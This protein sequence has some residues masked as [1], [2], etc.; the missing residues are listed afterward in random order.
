M[1]CIRSS[2]SGWELFEVVDAG[3]GKIALKGSNN[4]YVSSENGTASMICNK[5]VIG[6]TEK[7]TFIRI[8]DSKVAFRGNN[9][10]YICS[11]NGET[12]MICD[13]S[14]IASWE[15]F[16]WGENST[17]A[18]KLNMKKDAAEENVNMMYPNPSSGTIQIQTGSNEF[19][20]EIY[21]SRGTLVKKVEKSRNS[22]K[23]NIEHLSSGIYSVVIKEENKT[24]QKKLLIN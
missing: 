20:I 11:M 12:A 19:N 1:T 4:K 7:F 10:K 8:G 23:I 16:T 2:Y 18:K 3:N 24:T 22:E 9:G 5:T 21:N 17:T 13:K 6:T 14:V 15:S